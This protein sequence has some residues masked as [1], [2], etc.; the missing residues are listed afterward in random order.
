MDQSAEIAQLKKK[1]CELEKLLAKQNNG[2]VPQQRE[3]ITHMSSEV[4]DSNP[5]RY[6]PSPNYRLF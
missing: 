3:K 6:G 1:I 4:V 5:Y 2:V